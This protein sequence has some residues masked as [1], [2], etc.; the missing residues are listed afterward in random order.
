MPRGGD[1]RPLFYP[2]ALDLSYASLLIKTLRE[3]TSPDGLEFNR[4]REALFCRW[5]RL[6][7]VLTRYGT[8]RPWLEPPPVLQDF[9]KWFRNLCISIPATY[10]AANAQ[11]GSRA[12]KRT[13]IGRYQAEVERFCNRWRLRAW[14]AWPAVVNNHLL[15]VRTGYDWPLGIHSFGYWSPPDYPI[16]VDIPDQG[17]LAPSQQQDIPGNQQSGRSALAAAGNVDRQR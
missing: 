17:E 9:S 6:A 4:G 11:T 12:S 13:V 1:R 14:W 16:V 2:I 15:R 5:Q 10:T 3:D 8:T 7:K